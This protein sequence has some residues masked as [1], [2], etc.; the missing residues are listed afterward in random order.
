MSVMFLSSPGMD[1]G[2]A[3]RVLCACGL[4]E[5]SFLLQPRASHLTIQNKFVSLEMSSTN[6][7]LCYQLA[8]MLSFSC[9]VSLQRTAMWS[10]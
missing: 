4:N 1:Q 6:I 9:F 5:D 10:L 3:G 2:A 7:L 8:L